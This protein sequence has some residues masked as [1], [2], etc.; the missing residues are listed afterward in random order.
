MAESTAPPVLPPDAGARL[1]EFA[2]ACKAAARAVSLYPAA[3]P[4]IGTTL[5]RLSQV[6]AMLTANGPYRLQ[7]MADALLIG[8][9]VPARPDPAIAELA[10]LLHRQ[11]VGGLTLT[12]SVPGIHRVQ[13]TE[14]SATIAFDNLTFN[15]PVAAS[16]PEPGTPQQRTCLATPPRVRGNRWAARSPLA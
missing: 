16:V 3:H 9:A 14:T 6:T 1:A 10:E 12:L 11:L 15:A 5:G 13:L 7:V 8:G 2:R 4:A